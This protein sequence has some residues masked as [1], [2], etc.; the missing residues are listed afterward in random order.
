MANSGVLDVNQDLVWAGLGDRNLLVFDGAAASLED[1][2]PLF[3]G[4][5]SGHGWCLGGRL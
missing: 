4:E 3:F 2:C 5:F 1:L